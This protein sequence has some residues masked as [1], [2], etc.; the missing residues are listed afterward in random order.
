MEKIP[1]TKGCNTLQHTATHCSTLQLTAA[2]CS[3]LQ[4]TAKHCTTLQHTATL[5]NTLQRTAT[6]CNALQRTSNKG[7][8]KG[9]SS[10]VSTPVCPCNMV[11]RGV[12]QCVAMCCN[13]SHERTS[14]YLQHGSVC[15][16]A[17]QFVVLCYNVLQSHVN[18]VTRAHRFAPVMW[19]SILQCVELCCSVLQHVLQYVVLQYVAVCC[20]MLQCVTVYCSMLQRIAACC[21]LLE[22]VG[23]CC[24][25]IVSPVH[26][27]KVCVYDPVSYQHTATHTPTHSN[28]MQYTATQ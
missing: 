21:S 1:P 24:C 8:G 12:V 20:S 14:V 7:L 17:L 19:C 15:C 5:C 11:W 4:H 22:S 9:E 28:T 25:H 13:V 27:Y 3:T 2:N 23:V 6:H 16:S 26:P 10:C 18:A